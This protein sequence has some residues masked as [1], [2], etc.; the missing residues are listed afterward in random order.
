MFKLVFG[1]FT[2][3]ALAIQIEAP[4]VPTTTYKCYSFSGWLEGRKT[5]SFKAKIE[6][7]PDATLKKT[8][9]GSGTY[10]N[11]PVT[12]ENGNTGYH[13]SHLSFDVKKKDGTLNVTCDKTPEWEYPTNCQ[14][15]YNNEKFEL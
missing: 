8:F 10:N 13:A 14:G 12:I 6:T 1:A 7:S 5:L 9:V 4:S 11:L 2:M 15:R 3:S